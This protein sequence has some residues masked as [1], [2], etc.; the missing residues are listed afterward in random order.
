M[1]LSRSSIRA[2]ACSSK[3]L[4]PRGKPSPCFRCLKSPSFS[5]RLG[6]TFRGVV[7]PG[8]ASAWRSLGGFFFPR[9]SS[10]SQFIR[11]YQGVS[12]PESSE[13]FDNVLEICLEP[14]TGLAKDVGQDS[15]PGV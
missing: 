14:G 4:E 2:P 11:D 10:G 5:S 7:I 6:E 1:F 3:A 9:I 12:C 13:S 8:S 15:N